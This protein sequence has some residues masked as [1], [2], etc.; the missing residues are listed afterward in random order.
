[1][2]VQ[3]F[4]S[5]T[6]DLYSFSNKEYDFR[7]FICVQKNNRGPALGGCRLRPYLSER[8]AVIDVI[9]L[10]RAMRD[11]AFMSGLQHDGGKAVIMQ[12]AKPISREVLFRCFAECV[13][14]LKG[15]YITT[16]DSG[17]TAADMAIIKCYTPFVVGFESDDAV[18][19]ATALGAFIGI[20]AAINLHYCHPERSEGS[21]AAEKILRF[22]QD[23][24]V[25]VA[26]QGVGNVGLQLAKLLHESGARLTVSDVNPVRAKIAADTFGAIIV[27]SEDIY[28]VECDVFSPCALGR[29]IH[30]NN[31]DRFRTKIIAGAANDQLDS[32]KLSDQLNQKGI[33][34]VPDF[35][36]NAGGLIYLSRERDGWSQEAI[37]QDLL[38]I[39]E[40]VQHEIVLQAIRS[41]AP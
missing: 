22:A 7:A 9:R 26:I 28:Q 23:D 6:A 40:R 20:K 35:I 1:M 38:R 30:R 39:G 41:K 8:A 3:H 4:P 16:I 27:D 21:Y 10:S 13:D 2:I 11:K 25:H 18:A 36:L 33:M 24:N 14:S 37:R 29:I 5:K 19:F 15:R 32:K 12:S 34:Y 31:I 17:T